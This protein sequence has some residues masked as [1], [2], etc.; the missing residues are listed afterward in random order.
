MFL[1]SSRLGDK[2]V[3]LGCSNLWSAEEETL[4]VLQPVVVSLRVSRHPLSLVKLVDHHYQQGIGKGE[5]IQWKSG[6]W[7]YLKRHV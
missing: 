1:A 5:K 7:P 2:G 6:K 3:G 4:E